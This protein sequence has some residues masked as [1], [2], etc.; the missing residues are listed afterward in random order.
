MIERHIYTNEAHHI[1]QAVLPF[2][3]LHCLIVIQIQMQDTVTGIPYTVVVWAMH[4]P[5]VFVTAY[6]AKQ[7]FWYLKAYIHDQYMV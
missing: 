1:S 4:S 3:Y 6:Q 7:F 5:V 2:W